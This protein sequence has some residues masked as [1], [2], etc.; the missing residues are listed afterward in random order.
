M[1]KHYQDAGRG[2][3][4]PHLRCVRRVLRS[5]ARNRAF[6]P[7]CVLS[8]CF[9]QMGLRWESWTKTIYGP[10][11][12]GRP[13]L[14][15]PTRAVASCQGP[16]AAR[17][18]GGPRRT[19]RRGQR[20]GHAREGR[21]PC[22]RR[23]RAP[24]VRQGAR[25]AAPPRRRTPMRARGPDAPARPRWRDAV[26]GEGGQA[27]A[28]RARGPMRRGRRPWWPRPTQLGIPQAGQGG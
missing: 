19:P 22:G 9:E 7:R 17:Q 13:I 5:W 18:A 11:D 15:G 25:R 21:L 23:D 10:V 2:D 6:H 1:G 28:V 20:N 27:S 3:Q 4:R 26:R 14:P 16:G 24:R 8:S 12:T